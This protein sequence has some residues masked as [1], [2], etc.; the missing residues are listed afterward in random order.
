LLYHKLFTMMFGLIQAQSDGT[1]WPLS[2]A[3]ETMNQNK[4]L[5]L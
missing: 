3:S 4:S 5:L 2:E 1:K